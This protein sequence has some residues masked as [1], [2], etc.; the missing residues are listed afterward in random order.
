MAPAY[1]MRNTV[2]PSDP[3][4][5]VSGQWPCNYII[6]KGNKS[7][8][9]YHISYNHRVTAYFLFV[10]DTNRYINMVMSI[11]MNSLDPQ[12]KGDILYLAHE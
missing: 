1:L 6:F 11:S 7:Y 2:I 4:R 9:Y 8:F 10:C 3:K 12:Y 5:I